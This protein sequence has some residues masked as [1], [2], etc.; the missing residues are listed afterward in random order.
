MRA[1]IAIKPAIGPTYP[2]KS[3]S[4]FAALAANS[5]ALLPTSSICA[6][7]GSSVAMP[8][9]RLMLGAADR[10]VAGRARAPTRAVEETTEVATSRTKIST[11][12]C[13]LARSLQILDTNRRR[14]LAARGRTLLQTLLLHTAVNC[15]CKCCWASGHCVHMQ[16]R[17]FQQLVAA[18]LSALLCTAAC[19][20]ALCCDCCNAA[21]PA[22]CSARLCTPSLRKHEQLAQ[23]LAVTF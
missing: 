9:S 15:C 22:C 19:C 4:L 2:P 18:L 20:C 11:L 17:Q 1:P 14:V 5:I 3:A 16:N 8:A 6:C 7:E 10:A 21:A 12:H 23:L 13:E